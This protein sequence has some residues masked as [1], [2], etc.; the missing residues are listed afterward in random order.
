MS[1]PTWEVEL[2]LHARILRKDPVAS[3]EVYLAFMDPISRVLQHELH[4][5]PDDAYDS[6][7]DAVLV[8]L[9]APERY[10]DRKRLSTYLT[11]IAKRR[12]V[13]RKRSSQAR[14]LREEKFVG[15][16]E[17]GR[18]NPKETM[19]RSVEARDTVRMLEQSDLREKEH[20]LLEH[21]LQGEKSSRV[22][23]K[24]LELK[25]MSDQQERQEVKRHKDRL[26][27]KLVRIGKEDSDDKA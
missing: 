20:K 7:V 16:F 24:V 14:T 17:L 11:H 19:E 4:C 22:L 5:L 8:Y 6:A 3:K 2:A 26:L 1:F 21:M 9:R 12:A 18:P 27:K 23:G 13:D 10:D 15:K 25:P